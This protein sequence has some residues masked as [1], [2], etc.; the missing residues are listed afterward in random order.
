[1]ENWELYAKNIW[2][3]K[4]KEEIKERRT[5]EVRLMESRGVGVGGQKL[6]KFQM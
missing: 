6:F 5:W 1:M 2:T 4:L 3:G